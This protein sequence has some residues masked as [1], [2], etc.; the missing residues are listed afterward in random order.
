MTF[1]RCHLQR[2]NHYKTTHFKWVVARVH[3]DSIILFFG[4]RKWPLG[5]SH[6]QF[7]QPEIHTRRKMN[8]VCL[9]AISI[10]IKRRISHQIWKACRT[11]FLL[12]L[13]LFSPRKMKFAIKIQ[14]HVAKTVNLSNE[15]TY[16][17]S[18]NNNNKK[19]SCIQNVIKITKIRSLFCFHFPKMLNFWTESQDSNED[20]TN[21]CVT[22]TST[23]IYLFRWIF[24]FC[25]TF[26]VVVVFVVPACGF[27]NWFTFHSN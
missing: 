5:G 15:Y 16:I 25:R 9:D 14:C 1:W 6:C 11:V 12:L 20:L 22:L 7:R 17:N 4:R 18:Y 3:D 10:E 24:H 27:Y 8:D 13:L 2:A 23:S 26:F 21:E 19:T